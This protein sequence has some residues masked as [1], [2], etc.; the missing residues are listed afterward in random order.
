MAR[1]DAALELLDRQLVDNDGRLVG[2]VDDLELTDPGDRLEPPGV[3]AILTGP[4]AL[5][6]RLHTRFGRWLRPRSLRLA[7]RQGPS[8]VPFSQVEGIGSAIRLR[9]AANELDAAQE[10]ARQL[11]ARLPG[12]GDAPQ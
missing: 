11:I 1:L 6:G 2:K 3:T 10:W 12:A 4:D 9:V 7:A 8:R 5:A